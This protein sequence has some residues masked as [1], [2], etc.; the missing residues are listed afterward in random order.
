MNFYRDSQ[1]ATSCVEAGVDFYFRAAFLATAGPQSIENSRS[2]IS[3]G[4]G[5]VL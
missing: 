5:F 1:F 2:Q 3:E 4:G